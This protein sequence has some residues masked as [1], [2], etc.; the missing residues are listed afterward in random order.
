MLQIEWWM[1]KKPSILL[2][3]LIK[4]SFKK[5]PKSS[6]MRFTSSHC[7]ITQQIKLSWP[8]DYS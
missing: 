2:P 8:S 4:K 5:L 7:W 3:F 6:S 1:K